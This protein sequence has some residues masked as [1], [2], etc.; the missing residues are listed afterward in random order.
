MPRTLNVLDMELCISMCMYLLRLLLNRSLTSYDNLN[1]KSTTKW[2]SNTFI[3]RLDKL[4]EKFNRV[5]LIKVGFNAF[6]Q[7]PYD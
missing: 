3:K 6:S 5:Q 1:L 2:V 7:K 4:M